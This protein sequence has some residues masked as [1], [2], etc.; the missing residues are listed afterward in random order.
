MASL[1]K[2]LLLVARHLILQSVVEFPYIPNNFNQLI[3]I[4]ISIRSENYAW[5]SDSSRSEFTFT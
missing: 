4:G 2:F 3:T 5:L 1:P